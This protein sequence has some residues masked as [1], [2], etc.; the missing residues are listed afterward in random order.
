M[1]VRDLGRV[2][3]EEAVALQRDLLDRVADDREDD[4]LLFVEHPPVIT[5]GANFHEENLLASTQELERNGIL[6]ARTERGGD[7]TY[8]GPGQLVIYPVFNLKR[9][10]K[11]VHKWLRDLEEAVIQALKPFGLEGSR[12]P[13]HTG[14]W[15]NGGKVCAIGVK[16][17]RWTS[18][19]GLALNVNNDLAS[20]S[21]IVPCGISGHP[22]TSMANELARDVPIDEVKR[23]VGRAFASIFGRAAGTTVHDP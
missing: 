20:F 1:I 7:V 16:V 8:H 11:D 3:Y 12:F 10:G 23:E 18:M 6:V 13:P 4:T 15:V 14:V 9:H 21:L 17:R 19:H 22:V 2:G 5:L